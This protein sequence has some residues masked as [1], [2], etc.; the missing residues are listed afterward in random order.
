MFNPRVLVEKYLE[1]Q[2]ELFYNFIDFKKA[3]D[4]VWHDGLWR[5]LN[6]YNIDSQLIKVIRSLYDKR[7]ALCYYLEVLKIYFE[8]QLQYDKDVHYLQYHLIY[9]WKR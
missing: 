1:H 5:V 6:E 7:P 9:S 8:W 4:H 2:K 3:F